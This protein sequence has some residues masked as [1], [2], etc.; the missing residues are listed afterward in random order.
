MAV[1]RGR[2]SGLKCHLDKVKG[3]YLCE[4]ARELLLMFRKRIYR[5]SEKN[6]TR[7]EIKLVR[8]RYCSNISFLLL[9]YNLIEI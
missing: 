2:K 1:A 9:I 4:V 6:V 3:S 7:S 8:T 5:L